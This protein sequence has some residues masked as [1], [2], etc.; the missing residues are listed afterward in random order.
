MSKTRRRERRKESV[1]KMIFAVLL[2]CILCLDGLPLQ[3]LESASQ[4]LTAA[5]D[6]AGIS[7]SDGGMDQT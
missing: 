1:A 5:T 7:N 3:A 6:A 4:G 2:A